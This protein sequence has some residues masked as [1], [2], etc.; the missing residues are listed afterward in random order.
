MGYYGIGLSDVG[1]M[2]EIM[3]KKKG[4]VERSIHFYDVTMQ[5]LGKGKEEAFVNYKDQELKAIEVFEC[6]QNTD[7]EIK[8]EKDKTKKLELLEKIEYKTENG[9]KLYVKVDTINKEKKYI[10]FR[11]V[12]CRPDAFPYIEKDGELESIVGIVKGDFNIAEV[13]HCVLFYENGIM[14]GEYNFSG[15]RPSAIAAY[16]SSRCDKVERFNC[17]PKMN[18]DV[19]R[20]IADD[21]EYSLFQLK[22]KNTPTMK[23]L[24]RDKMGFIGSTINEIDELDSYEII[25]RRRTGKRKAG[26]PAL[27]QKKEIRDFIEKNSE[28]IEK[29]KINQG[30]YNDPINLLSDRIVTKKEFVMTKQ[31]TIDSAS[32][33]GAIENFYECSVKEEE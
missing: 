15:A 27:M 19:Y 16:V 22:V 33:Y 31:K 23:V 7:K 12:L 25:L 8:K 9:D 5:R 3:A 17:T 2:E 20:K 28:D 10:E 14:G 30:I 21:K 6:F 29:F 26:F 18:G 24:L 4:K 11:L 13:T 32:M 1:N